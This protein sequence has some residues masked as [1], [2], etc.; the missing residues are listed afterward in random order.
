MY[1]KRASRITFDSFGMFHNPHFKWVCKTAIKKENVEMMVRMKNC[2]RTVHRSRVVKCIRGKNR[3]TKQKRRNK[4]K[5]SGKKSSHIICKTLRKLGIYSSFF[6]SFYTSF[7][8][9]N[10]NNIVVVS[11]VSCS[12][13]RN[14]NQY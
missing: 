11:F 8:V 1:A 3:W 7:V 6:D 12:V 13:F 10:L 9:P 2:K 5:K 4:W 14:T